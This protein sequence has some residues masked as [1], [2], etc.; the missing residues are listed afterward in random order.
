[1]PKK[2]TTFEELNSDDEF[3]KNDVTSHSKKISKSKTSSL[4][5][6]KNIF[7]NNK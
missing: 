6:T 3:V 5:L 4:S 1:V 2:A 7:N